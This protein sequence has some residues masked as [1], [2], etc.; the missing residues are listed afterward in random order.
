MSNKIT[1]VKHGNSID[2]SNFYI[3]GE[4]SLYSGIGRIP[5]C[6]SCLSKIIEDYYEVF[7]DHKVA[8]Y[9]TLR[10]MDVG[11]DT[12]IYEGSIKSGDDAT[13]ILGFYMRMRNSLG[14]KNNSMLVFDDGENIFDNMEIEENEDDMFAN[15]APLAQMTKEDYKNKE[16]V[17]GLLGYDPFE[18]YSESDQKTLYADLINYLS[19]E[20]VVEDQFLVSQIIQVVLNNDQIRKLNFAI[21]R[22][23]SSPQLMLEHEGKIKSLGRTKHDIVTSTDKIAKE[24]AITV[25]ARGGNKSGQS[26]LTGMMHK[27][28]ELKFED[29]EVDYYDQMMSFGMKRAADI[30]MKAM[31]EQMN[32]DEDDIRDMLAGQREKIQSLSDKVLHLEE[33]KRSLNAKIQKAGV[34]DVGKQDYSIE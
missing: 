16:E 8:L 4:N 22:F 3:S 13:T 21:N 10:K 33:E 29:A 5:I 11:F 28:R 19:D 30:S 27:L 6:K 2:E 23:M 34:I 25:K 9:H 17:I 26:S 32:F 1:C 24:N 7:R 18:G 14:T 31:Y 15:L 20:D 12:G